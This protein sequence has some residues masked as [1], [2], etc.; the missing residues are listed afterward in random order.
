M[1]Q[2]NIIRNSKVTLDDAKRALHIYG[3]DP[4]LI[5]G[6][7]VKR[8]QSKVQYHNIIKLPKHILYKHKKV[9]L[10]V[11]YMFVQG[12]QFLTTISHELK[13]RTVEA[14]LFT[15]KKGARKEDILSGLTKV[16][17]LY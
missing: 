14:L 1:L 11:D 16:I 5:K 10:M 13:Y 9:H 7:T 2:H 8:K 4:A 6:K 3:E 12:I 17:R 15:Y